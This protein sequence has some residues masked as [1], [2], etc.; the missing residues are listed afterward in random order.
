MWIAKCGVSGCA[1]VGDWGGCEWG[2]GMGCAWK[3]CGGA[4]GGVEVKGV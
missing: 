4:C 3:R 1:G 2:G